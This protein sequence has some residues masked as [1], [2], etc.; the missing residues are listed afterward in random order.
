M[1][2]WLAD[3]HG[4]LLRRDAVES[5]IDDNA[6]RR[7]VLTGRIV[8]LRQGAYVLAPV[9]EAADRV[10]RH[11]LLVVAVR[12][13]YGNDVALSHTSANIEQ[14]GP[15]WGLDL[16]AVHLTNLYGVGERSSAKVVHHRGIC[17]A[18]DITCLDG[19]WITAPAR[20]AMDTACISSRDPAVVV[21]DYF[22]QSGLAT[23]EQLEQVLASMKATPG[24]LSLLPKLR[25]SD[26]KA[27]SVGETRSRLL[28]RNEGLPAP[29]AQYEIRHPAGHVA[30]R[31]DFAWPE[32]KVMAEFDGVQKYLRLRRKGE[33]LEEA[34]LREKAREDHLR[35]ITG[36]LMVRLVWADLDHP[37][38][39]ANRILR[40]FAQAAA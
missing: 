39:T 19:G 36:W 22:Q 30:G 6:L 14:G 31:V 25:L 9:W 8:R 1:L 35:E 4:V 17:R 29:I 28:F 11:R 24:S 38:V 23:R 40:A 2:E 12:K 37:A 32:R 34:I 20:T 7:A 21:L 10:G 27:E 5:G 18:G 13:Q 26:G 16:R 3:A 15:S 33:S